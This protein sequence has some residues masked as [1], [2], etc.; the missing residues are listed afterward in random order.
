MGDNIKPNDANWRFNQDFVD[1]FD[2]NVSKSFPFYNE[3]HELIE[4]Y[5]IFLFLMIQYVMK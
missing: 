5:Q 4:E 1:C 2:S 3:G